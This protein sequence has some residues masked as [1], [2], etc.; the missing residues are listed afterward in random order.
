MRWYRGWTPL[1]VAALNGDKKGAELLLDN[2][3]DVN[4]KDNSG[5]T[6]LRLV[7]KNA[8][9]DVDELLRQHVGHEGQFS[10]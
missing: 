4:P 10:A 1:Y 7:A 9:K 6:L 3:A 5:Y 8:A 2:K